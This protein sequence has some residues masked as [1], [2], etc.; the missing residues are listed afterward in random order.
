MANILAQ[1][2]IQFLDDNGDPIALGTITTSET[3]TSTPKATYTDSSESTPNANPLTLD[4]GGRADIW[5]LS[6]GDYRFVIKNAAGDTL[7]TYDNVTT[8]ASVFNTLLTQSNNIDM[9]G[10][11]IVTNN[12]A[13]LPLNPNGTGK[14]DIHRFKARTDVDLNGN[15]LVIDN[16]NGFYGPSGVNEVLIMGDVASA[17]NN[18]K[19]TNKATGSSPT[20]EAIGDDTNIGITFTP[21][22][23]GTIQSGHTVAADDD[24][25][26]KAYVDST[27]TSFLS[28]IPATASQVQGDT[29]TTTCLTPQNLRYATERLIGKW[30]QLNNLDSVTDSHGSVSITDFG[31]G[32]I[33]FN[34]GQ[35]R[36]CFIAQLTTSSGLTSPNPRAFIT[37]NLNPDGI[38]ESAGARETWGVGPLTDNVDLD[39]FWVGGE[40]PP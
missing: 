7:Y 4:A 29:E 38:G 21:K 33:S 16:D 19:I 31:V 24:L 14:T 15:N 1:P 3:G 10:F 30:I 27:N 13:D 26:N 20:I 11:S 8:S 6:D 23:T 34:G 25:A 39:I 5:L 40:D 22:G 18:L 37:T 2:K 17:V 35:V 28:T 12:N 32:N 36:N 9:N